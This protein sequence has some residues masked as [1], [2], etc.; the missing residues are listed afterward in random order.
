MKQ[1]WTFQFFEVVR[2]HILGVVENVIPVHRFVGNL[3]GF[4]VVKEIWKSVSRFDEIISSQE[5]GAFFL[6]MQYS[7]N[8]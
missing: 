2:Q 5:G 6:G 1:I 4:P 7:C 8:P 3:T